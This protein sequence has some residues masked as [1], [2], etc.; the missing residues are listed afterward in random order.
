MAARWVGIETVQFVE[1]EPFAQKVLNKNFPNIPIHDDIKTFKADEFSGIG[2]VTGGYPCQPFSQAGQRRGEKDDRHLW[3][4]MFRVIRE[5]RPVWVLAENVAGHVSMGLDDVL[6]DLES[7]GYTTQPIIIPACAKDA[8]HRR[9]RVWIVANS[10]CNSEGSAYRSNC[11]FSSGGRQKQS[12]GE[13]NEMGGNSGNSSEDVAD[14][15]S[16]GWKEHDHLKG[17]SR[18]GERTDRGKR[19]TFGGC[20]IVADSNSGFSKRENKGIFAGGNSAD[21]GSEDVAYSDSTGFSEQ[22]RAESI[23]EKQFTAECG[24]RWSIEPDVGRVAHGVRSRVDRL[25]GLG[26][27]IVPQ[28]A[29][30][31]MRCLK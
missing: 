24:S 27:A 4:E 5:A 21:N 19:Q 10:E 18:E 30:E 2:I 17:V 14:S 1:I 12:V 25:R 8:K 29:F 11:G 20:S 9:D 7:E 22:W 26:N 6:D 16:N 15:D 31:I 23:R 28:V 13:W 3:P